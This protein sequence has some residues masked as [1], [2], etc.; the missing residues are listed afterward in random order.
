MWR[1]HWLTG[2]CPNRSLES[3]G[4]FGGVGGTPGA[5]PASAPITNVNPNA[6]RAR[7][8]ISARRDA[9]GAMPFPD[10][11]LSGLLELKTSPGTKVTRGCQYETATIVCGGDPH[12]PPRRRPIERP[13]ER[14]QGRQG[15]RPLPSSRDASGKIFERWAHIMRRERQRSASFCR[16]S[17]WGASFIAAIHSVSA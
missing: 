1:V 6:T 2:P 17:T 13:N 9:I 5:H 12:Y 7:S 10:G 14:A 3:G 4:G 15:A 11:Q 8:P 16:S